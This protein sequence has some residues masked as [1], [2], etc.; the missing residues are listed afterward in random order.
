MKRVVAGVIA[1][2]FVASISGPGKAVADN[3]EAGIRIMTQNL[4]EGTSFSELLLATTPQAF[5]AAVTAT[6]QNI[7]ATKPAVRAAAI[8]REIARER[9][10]LVALQEAAI[11]RTALVPVTNPPKPVTTVEFDQLELLLAELKR[12]GHP[13]ETVSIL[14]NLDAQAPS[15]TGASVRITVRTVIIARSNPDDV[16][17]SNVQAQEYLDFAS[18]PTPVGL[19][20]PNQRGWTSVDVKVNGRSA[21]FITTHLD[22][23][24]PLGA[25]Q[26]SELLQSAVNST[27]LPV[28]LVGDFNVAANLPT[29]PSFANYQ[30]LLNGGFVDAWV[31]KHSPG[32]G[33]TCC[34]TA[35]VSV[36][37][38]NFTLRVDLVLLR[39][40]IDIRD[41]HLVGNT[42]A[43]FVDGVW[44]SDHAGI[45]AT[46][47][48]P[49]ANHHT[50]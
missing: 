48:I 15:S 9:P 44:P 4:Y 27:A 34:Q 28:V 16:Q 40:G 5:V 26:I 49:K 8:A 47:R 31:E 6:R 35:S 11:L 18:L 33:L 46:L 17:L 45:V 41:I 12:L 13:Y 30:A 19:S 42:P 25:L 38:P 3:D 39:G 22:Q 29:D 14:P 32:P 50:Q 7:L 2:A 1:L 10:D 36:P 24:V 37:T 23:S 20:I 21:R 43:D